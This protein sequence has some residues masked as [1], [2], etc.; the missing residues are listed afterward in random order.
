M[1]MMIKMGQNMNC[2]H[3]DVVSVTLVYCLGLV[4]DHYVR[5]TEDFE[6]SN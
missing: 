2:W 4:L 1:N 6:I 3:W 5:K